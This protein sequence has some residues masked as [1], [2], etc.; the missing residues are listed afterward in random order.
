[1][2]HQLTDATIA[3]I[4]AMYW[5]PQLRV[6]VRTEIRK[7]QT[8][9]VRN[10]APSVPILGQLPIDRL[11]PY[12]RPFTNTGLDYFGPVEVT[13]GRR[14]EKRWVALFTCMSVR[15]VH[16]EIATNLSTDACLV[17]I[18][19][20]CNL[21]GVPALIRCDNGT[22]FVGA[23]NELNRTDEF[24]E[25]NAI[26]NA[27]SGRGIQWKHNCPGN[28]EAGGAWERLVQSVKRVLAVTLREVA[29]QV[30]TLRAHLL[31][32]ANILNS[33]PLTHIPVEPEDVDIITPNH[34]LLGGMNAAT[35]PAPLNDESLHTRRQWRICVEL[36]RRFWNQ[37]IRDYL[38]EL[39]RRSRHY[40]ETAQLKP[41]DLV[42]IC[43]GNIPRARWA[44]GRIVSTKTGQDKI[45]RTAEVQTAGGLLHR[46]A[47]K[48]AILDVS[49]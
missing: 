4:R 25:T 36:S 16:L 48:L 10:A 23:R 34:F 2:A 46:P 28:P 22:N 5:V 1:M 49:T 40:P 29:P 14:R 20:L 17:C 27:L 18:R 38:P 44:R 33:R 42:I 45:V 15:A 41:G 3:A 6:L 30:E 43:E 13:I 47:T 12:L 26:Q 32:A 37:W 19:N 39:T 35:T 7:C 31:E 8:C 9:R 11:T 21:R 24:F